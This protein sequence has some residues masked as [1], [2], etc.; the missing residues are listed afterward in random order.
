MSDSRPRARSRASH[1]AAT[2]LVVED[3]HDIV[4]MMTH[5]LEGQGYQVIGAPS[6]TQALDCL[7]TVHIDLAIID[8]DLPEQAGV[9]L[10]EHI[11]ADADMRQLPVVTMTASPL[12]LS[13]AKAAVESGVHEYLFKPFM[14]ETL[15]HNVGRLLS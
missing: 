12:R 4:R 9:M 8:L 3:E 15:L 14:A 1:S 11:R 6:R 13:D 7:R 10:T 5:T 2:I